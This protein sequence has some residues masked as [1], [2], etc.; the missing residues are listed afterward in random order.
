MAQNIKKY[1]NLENITLSPNNIERSGSCAVVVLVVGDMVYVSNVGDSRSILSSENG[2]KVYPLTKDHKPTD[3]F[4][5][6]R[7]LENGGKIY[8]AQTPINPNPN[9]KL[10]KENMILGPYRVL[11]GR[12]SVSRTFGD[13][14]SK[15]IKYGGNPN[16]IIAE[17]EIKAF[18]ISK[19]YDFIL[20]AS[21]G[22]FDKLNN[23][24]IVQ[25]I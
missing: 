3:P 11:P 20:L 17:P 16:V 19:D 22:I 5:S 9:M 13:A 14:E 8:R 1:N 23:K 12:L 15:L 7:I 24:E 10:N 6:K 25:L 21:D 4:E 2:T 18:K